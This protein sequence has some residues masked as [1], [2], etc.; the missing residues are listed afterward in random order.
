MADMLI[1]LI[2]LKSNLSY[3]ILL[4]FFR[5]NKKNIYFGKNRVKALYLLPCK[6]GDL[7]QVIIKQLIIP[8]ARRAKLAYTSS[9]F[10]FPKYEFKLLII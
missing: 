3:I 7:I 4:Y 1:L 8:V 5:A 2:V 6:A 10:M 9:K